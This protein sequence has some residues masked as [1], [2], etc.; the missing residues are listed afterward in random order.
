MHLALI[1][2]LSSHLVLPPSLSPSPS[3]FLQP[4]V[5][6]AE[7][8][9]QCPCWC[10]HYCHYSALPP[11]DLSSAVADR[12]CLLLNYTFIIREI[13][14]Y[15]GTVIFPAVKY[16]PYL[17]HNTQFP[18]C[19]HHNIYPFCFVDGCVQCTKL[20]HFKTSII[21]TTVRL[22]GVIQ[23]PGH[24]FHHVGH[25]T[26]S[27]SLRTRKS[28]CLR[29]VRPRNTAAVYCS[30]TGPVGGSPVFIHALYTDACACT[31]REN[32]TIWQLH[33]PALAL[34]N[35]RWQRFKRR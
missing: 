6:P 24:I 22:E 14:K 13:F 11:A 12:A 15:Y 2:F 8:E 35:D 3:P 5:S 34:C 29:F 1:L 25:C 30:S 7:V 33:M 23:E 4:L 28:H 26:I 20:L 31:V 10:H 32:P 9:I 19:M 21:L 18:L 17:F 27:G 16:V